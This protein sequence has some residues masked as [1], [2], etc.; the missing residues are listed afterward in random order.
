MPDY[1]YAR[2]DGQTLAHDLDTLYAQGLQV[3]LDITE[4]GITLP[5]EEYAWTNTKF[6]GQPL[7]LQDHCQAWTS[8]SFLDLA[9]VGQ[10]SPAAVDLPAWYSNGYWTQYATKLCTLKLHFFCFEQ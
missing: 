7:S 4:H 5:P 9:R 3:P 2:R 10:I 8:N 1:P 6:D